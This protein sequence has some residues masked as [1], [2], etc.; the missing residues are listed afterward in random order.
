M[1]H[2]PGPEDEEH[3]DEPTEQEWDEWESEKEKP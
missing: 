1:M 2:L 3:L